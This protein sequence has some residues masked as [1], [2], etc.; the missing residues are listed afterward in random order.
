MP[1]L[2]R[3]NFDSDVIILFLH[4]GAGGTSATHIEDFSGMVEKEY[5]VAYWDQR[6]AGSSQGNFAKEDLTI[7]LM[8]EDMQMVINMLKH[9]YGDEKKIFAMGHS[10]G[11]ILGTHYLI[12]QE[13][14]LHG[15]IF[16]NGAHSSE[17]EYSARMDYIR[18]FAKEMIDKGLSIS[19]P[20]NVEGETFKS[21]EEIVN[22]TE[23]NDPIQTW[24]Q[25]KI[26]V[27]LVPAVE[28]YVENTY[29]QNPDAIGNVSFQELR[30]QSPY[31][32]I[33]GEI[34][35]VSTAR[36]IN[37]FAAETSIQEFYDFTPEMIKIDIPI[38]LIWGKYDPI[39][40]LEVAEDYYEVIGT[41]E[42]SKELTVLENSGH[43][44]IYRENIKFSQTLIDFIEKHR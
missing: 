32:T 44:G 26:Q 40:G 19:E 17:H 36:I 38:S 29:F 6:H 39:V 22:W 16:S 28:S 2:V 27:E 34:N 10:W 9:K 7:E 3:G 42:E 13:N 21:L 11:V 14:Q 12:S 35:Q 15:A 31:F 5:A 41:P 37:N 1:V 4:G 18:E 24:K 20:I 30:F 43:S 33:G 23:Q 25:L 8:S